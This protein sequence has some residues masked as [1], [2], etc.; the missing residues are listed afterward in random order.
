M[1]NFLKILLFS[2]GIIAFYALFSNYGIPQIKPSP[3]PK[4]ETIALGSMTMEE[5]IALGEKIFNGKGTCTLCH[6][7]I[8]AGRA[9]LLDRVA[10]GADE[11]LK[12]PRYKGKAKT[13][14]EYLRESM[15]EPSA[16]VVAGF[17][18]KGTNDTQ[19]PMPDVR[20]GAIGLSDVEIDAVIAFLQ[21]RS[22]VEVSV[23]IPTGAPS[24]EERPTEAPAVAKTPQEVIG[25]FG[26]GTCHKIAG[27]M[28]VLA[29]DLT[30]IGAVRKEDYLRR[31]I[32]EPDADI[33]KNC[34]TGPCLPG[35]MPKDYKDKMLVSE[36]EMLVRFLAESK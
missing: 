3:P 13:S 20:T 5:F 31:A 30:K 21:K 9:P 36:L 6:N 1:K 27:Q 29:P 33:A 23:K 8:L 2:I 24:K 17:G 28:G 18:V 25:K 10:A 16:F 19:S 4:E 22:G 34:P 35:L 12:D 14:E 7:P 32:L 26:C 11:R 15:T